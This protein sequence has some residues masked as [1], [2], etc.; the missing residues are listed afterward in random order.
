MANK[1]IAPNEM[2]GN[3][4]PG[5]PLQK[6]AAT[7]YGGG[8][9]IEFKDFDAF[10]DDFFKSIEKDITGGI[11]SIPKSFMADFKKGMTT[12]D[13]IIE[14]LKVDVK[15]PSDST[16]LS[17][18]VEFADDINDLPGSVSLSLNLNP[19]D[20]IQ[21]PGKEAST[22]VNKLVEGTFGY[23]IKNGTW[24]FSDVD[25][26]IERDF[27]WDPLIK[28]RNVGVGRLSSTGTEAGWLANVLEKH[29]TGRDP[30]ATSTT[31]GGGIT[32]TMTQGI[33]D[34]RSLGTYYV[35]GQG[36]VVAPGNPV[37]AVQESFAKGMGM[38]KSE[39]DRE[40]TFTD[41]STQLLNVLD[42][43]SL[44]DH[45]VNYN[46]SA[47][48]NTLLNTTFA[49]DVQGNQT[50]LLDIQGNDALTG[51]TKRLS[52]LLGER[53]KREES[54]TKAKTELADLQTQHAAAT[55]DRKTKL[56]EL[57]DKKNSSI[58]KTTRSIELTNENIEWAV[59]SL[60]GTDPTQPGG[61]IKAVTDALDGG[62]LDASRDQGLIDLGATLKTHSGSRA[63]FLK[64]VVD[65]HIETAISTARAAT[66]ST[67]DVPSSG[68]LIYRAQFDYLTS[69]QGF[70]GSFKE[71][72]KG[73][74]K[75]MLDK[76]NP[77]KVQEV[78]TEIQRLCDAQIKQ[79]NDLRT[80]LEK[81]PAAV[82][83][84]D[85]IFGKHLK[86]VQRM[87]DEVAGV[88]GD[89]GM[90]A[91][92]KKYKSI[93]TT[94][95]IG[96]GV[97][98]VA[99]RR[100]MESVF[101][102]DGPLSKVFAGS[103]SP[104]LF[105]NSKRLYLISRKRYENEAARDWATKIVKG[106][107]GIFEPF[108]KKYVK[109]RFG[110]AISFDMGVKDVLV[111]NLLKPTHFFGLAFD[112]DI[113]EKAAERRKT[114]RALGKSI[115]W[116]D[117][118]EEK[119]GMPLTKLWGE[120][121]FSVTIGGKAFGMSGGGHLKGV[122]AIGQLIQNSTL[123]ASA[124]SSILNS[125]T[126]TDLESALSGKALPLS[127]K[128]AIEKLLSQMGEFREWLSKT[129]EGKRLAAFL[130]ITI[131]SSGEV[132]VNEKLM[133]F[134]KTV[135]LRSFNSATTDPT[136]LYVG[137]LRRLSQ[138]LSLLQNKWVGLITNFRKPIVYIKTLITEGI[139]QGIMAAL[140]SVT[141]MLGEILRVAVRVVVNKVVD[142]GE[143][144]LT[145]LY[146]FDMSDLM[147]DVT[148][149]MG[150]LIKYLLYFVIA[151]LILLV[152]LFDSVDSLVA[153][154]TPVD[155]S[156]TDGVLLGDCS[157]IEAHA[158]G[159]GSCGVCGPSGT[160]DWSPYSLGSAT[161]T[162]GIAFVI[163]AA[164]NDFDVPA[165]LLAAIFYS[166]DW[167]ENV[168]GK[169]QQ[170]WTYDNVCDWSLEEGPLLPECESRTSSSD[171]R[172]SFQWIPGW[173]EGHVDAVAAVTPLPRGTYDPCN[174]LDAAY[175]TAARFKEMANAAGVSGCS[176]SWL[177][178]KGS[179]GGGYA[180]G[181][182][183]SATK[184]QWAIL[185]Y[186]CGAGGSECF[187][188]AFLDYSEKGYAVFSS[189]KCF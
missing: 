164:A 53:K 18:P 187:S 165:P 29:L 71:L 63:D 31:G 93:Y 186:A 183:A 81:D 30:A 79:H 109:E 75:K 172:G 163:E 78:T 35:V 138:S 42:K 141:G 34:Y 72:H 126:L 162:D 119:V 87:R 154:S 86:A 113:A 10:Y 171:A 92:L 155:N 4:F 76:K 167:S 135:S 94:N 96:G 45:S 61:L 152:M 24:K 122:V 112:A 124:F 88:N 121:K 38:L 149:T 108:V 5:G 80:L 15:R 116:I 65:G 184:A 106:P 105:E 140:D 97:E 57:I 91:F 114:A 137:A 160:V 136:Q 9:P 89:L 83:E 127:D 189:L 6:R 41:M 131:S 43:Q 111:E 166:E 182:P 64:A 59:T 69:V 26:N 181:L 28:G 144:F 180:D 25:S 23:N 62:G 56:Q 60:Y 100:F 90:Q 150:G 85:T 39:G 11:T 161:F 120:N 175:A 177:S 40:S 115:G 179:I 12:P 52:A 33:A 95:T 16:M 147:K 46:L 174:F 157:E 70:D 168:A 130:G 151:P 170:P 129:D 102:K 3:F 107:S 132:V 77:A 148:E 188:S 125:H 51:Y 50:R 103:A 143:K 99:T 58:A 20:W 173:F 74:A 36:P 178:P 19:V 134:F 128:E 14:A 8:K 158:E 98:D 27:V 2:L 117:S 169:F 55:G 47:Q 17:I 67:A 21:D 159:V 37:G 110:L 32:D 49:A 145:G 1:V 101:I 142:W 133:S 139:T 156:R 66:K 54:L 7:P 44:R 82:A 13:A 73:L 123:D 104:E 153:G 146:K 68:S 22:F 84:F 176:S 118:L 48:A 185:H